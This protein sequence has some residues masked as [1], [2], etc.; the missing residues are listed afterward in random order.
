MGIL[1][2]NDSNILIFCPVPAIIGQI[3]NNVFL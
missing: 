1:Y 2:D 3:E